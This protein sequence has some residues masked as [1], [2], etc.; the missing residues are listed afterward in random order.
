MPTGATGQLG[1][2]LPVQGELT[3]VWGNTVNN[4]ITEYT[5]IAIAAT[6]TLTNDGAVTLANTTGDASASNIVST[7]TGA[8]TVTAQFAIIRVTGTLTVAK[9]VTAPAYSKTYVVV[10]AATGSTVTF[11]AAGQTGVSIAVG[12][13]A[14]VYFNGTDYVKLAGTVNTGVTSFTAG[15]T[16]FTPSTSTTG[17][18]TLAGTLG[19]ANGGTNLGGATPFT[20]GGVVYASSTSALATGSA[21]TFDGTN[22]F[23]TGAITTTISGKTAQ[24]TAAGTSIYASFADGTTTWRLGAGIQ[25]AGQFN[26]YDATNA[27]TALSV[28]AGASGYTAFLQNNAEQMR[29]TSTGLGIGTSSP[30]YK[31][32]TQTPITVGVTGTN[33]ANNTA[34]N[35]AFIYTDPGSVAAGDG[36]AIAIG[37]NARARVYI[38]ATHATTSKDYS[39]LALWTTTGA[40]PNERLRITSEGNVGIGTS[41]PNSYSGYTTLT[42]NNATTGGV[43]DLNVNGTRTGSFL[44]DSVKTTIGS[45]TS[46]PLVFNT[47]NTERARITSAGL[48]GIGTSSPYTKLDVRGNVFI[49]T[50]ATGDNVL[51]FG[52][53][54]GTGVLSG[55]PGSVPGNSFIV[56]DSADVSGFPGFLKFYTTD[57]GSVTEKMRLTAPG[58]L[59]VGGIAARGTTVG[60]CH[61]DLFNGQPPVGTLTNGVSLYSSSGD[62]K[63]MNAAGDAFDVGYR[64]IPQNSQSANYT[65][66]L[67]DAG[68]HIFHPVGDNNARTFTIPANSSVAY[69]IGTAITFINMAVANV[70][71]AITTDTMYLSSAGTTGSRTLAQYG[72][73]TAIKI[74]STNWLISGSGLT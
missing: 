38:S 27:Q 67:A 7:L 56:G 58:N 50:L 44:T 3:G 22:L 69:P 11:K 55:A 8:G 43:V 49:G 34:V 1:L 74:T 46:I 61:L 9:V 12:E 47:N 28:I 41:S 53:T 72:S 54:T 29:L 62:L 6:L 23:G 16:G 25:G 36:K 42:L 21:L 30:S 70:T 40:V 31:L 64:N 66:T 10:N 2:A 17:A 13:S 37:M 35:S 14:F 57:S 15:T 26:L 52:N 45:I 60:T 5:N 73:A 32:E 24:L 63:F 19:T 4:G 18:V 39:D 68:D 71:I 20:S 51:G 59:L 65:L 33:L 48:V